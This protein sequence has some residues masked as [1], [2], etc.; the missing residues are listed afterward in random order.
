M[1]LLLD[2]DY[3][4]VR[5]DSISK[6]RRIILLQY[7]SENY[8]L[9]QDRADNSPTVSADSM[10]F[11]RH[12]HDRSRFSGILLVSNLKFKELGYWMWQILTQVRREYSQ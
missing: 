10:Q 11:E 3:E 8:L 5:V 2:G 12:L 4:I 6:P 7:F 1:L 9:E